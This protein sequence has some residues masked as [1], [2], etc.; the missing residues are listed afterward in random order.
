MR[1]FGIA[2][3]TGLLIGTDDLGWH[4]LYGLVHHLEEAVH[5][6]TGAFGGVL[7]WLTNTAASAVLGLIVGA[8][9]VAIMHVLPIGK[10]DR[11]A[12]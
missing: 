6:A 1:T 11:H 10:K 7:A 8:V 2:A 9:V 4:W 12:A 5:H 3:S